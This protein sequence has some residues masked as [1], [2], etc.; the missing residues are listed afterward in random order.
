[1]R[2]FQGEGLIQ[3]WMND[4]HRTSGGLLPAHPDDCPAIGVGDQIPRS[5]RFL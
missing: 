4:T 1:M 3:E 2:Q 5:D